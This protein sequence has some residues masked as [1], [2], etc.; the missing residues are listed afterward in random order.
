[1][2]GEAGDVQFE[3][4]SIDVLEGAGE[5]VIAAS[6]IS[7]DLSVPKTA[8]RCI[9]FSPLASCISI[10]APNSISVYIIYSSF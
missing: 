9:E 6:K 8:A 7:R 4:R 10:L 2:I 5:D 3:G 1:M